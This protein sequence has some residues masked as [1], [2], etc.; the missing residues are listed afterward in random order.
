MGY[1]EL[2]M[3]RRKLY[4]RAIEKYHMQHG[5]KYVAFDQTLDLTA[6][7]PFY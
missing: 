3:N 2:S 7:V 6:D 1:Y 5:Q 4:A